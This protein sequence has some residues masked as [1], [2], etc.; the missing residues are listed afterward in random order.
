MG[1]PA[2]SANPFDTDSDPGGGDTP[3]PKKTVAAREDAQCEVQA[4]RPTPVTEEK[5]TPTTCCGWVQMLTEAF[6]ST[7]Q[8]LK[9]KKIVFASAC[10]GTNSPQ[11]A[12]QA[13]SNR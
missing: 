12:L 7:L 8:E 1:R 13:S 6:E 4:P 3:V 9:K 10:S 2:V 11:I 5:V